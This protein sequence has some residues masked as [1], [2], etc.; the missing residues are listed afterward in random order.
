[1]TDQTHI[2]QCDDPIY[3]PF[4]RSRI[5]ALRAT[6]LRFG[7][8]KFDVGGVTVSVRIEGEQS[9]VSITGGDSEGEFLVVPH[10]TLH[11]QG[12]TVSPQAKVSVGAMKL[13][14]V[15][16][17]SLEAERF[18]WS[19]I[20]GTVITFNH[21]CATRHRINRYL[22]YIGSGNPNIYI[23]GRKVTTEGIPVKGAARCSFTVGDTNKA[24]LV[25]ANIAPDARTLNIYYQRESGTSWHL[26][27][28]SYTCEDAEN[29]TAL[30][31]GIS[32]TSL[33]YLYDP[34]YFSP[35]GKN[36]ATLTTS[37]Y[38]AQHQLARVLQGTL[39]INN[40]GTAPVVTFSLGAPEGG[41][42]TTSSR[43]DGEFG[44]FTEVT[45]FT[46]TSLLGVDFDISGSLVRLWD[47]GGS[48]KEVVQTVSD[49]GNGATEGA[50]FIRRIIV[51]SHDRTA[52]AWSIAVDDLVLL[53]GTYSGG[54]TGSVEDRY[55]GES[56]HWET[57]GPGYP[58]THFIYKI[59]E[60][61]KDVSRR[62]YCLLFSVDIRSQTFLSHIFTF[63][64]NVRTKTVTLVT[65]AIT[66]VAL[67]SVTVDYPAELW[68]CSSTVKIHSAGAVTFSRECLSDADI[69]STHF[70]NVNALYG[71]STMT[72]FP[73]PVATNKKNLLVSFHPWWTDSDTDFFGVLL[74]LTKE[75]GNFS[76]INL[77]GKHGKPPV[78]EM[79]TRFSIGSEPD[80]HFG[81]VC[82]L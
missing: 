38:V 53:S 73:V 78:T 15:E 75:Q 55:E 10:S 31:G 7:S 21:G 5:K 17:V 82:I 50:W 40:E 1:M 28:T 57:P 29:A 59:T 67:P 46:Y 27:D 2:V 76:A 35:N 65:D 26:A 23:G 66:G 71:V 81:T 12:V 68:E 11:P 33:Q 54:N 18:D 70:P 9:F 41:G 63:S 14:I 16:N 4:A 56:G 49:V 74:G 77:L 36:L 51:G 8:Q 64:C 47:R 52:Q 19:G 37:S 30:I 72:G 69:P 32:Y 3:L 80:F 43:T 58:I 61:T 25:I 45:T 6:G 24:F 13:K 39:A 44:V 62:V 79:N 48:T 42:D 60:T 22:D 20:D 34:V